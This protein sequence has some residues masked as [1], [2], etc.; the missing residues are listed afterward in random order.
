M[1]VPPPFYE[2]VRKKDLLTSFLDDIIFNLLSLYPQKR[3]DPLTLLTQEQLLHSIK[4]KKIELKLK[5]KIPAPHTFKTRWPDARS[6]NV[7]YCVSKLTQHPSGM[8][9][10][11]KA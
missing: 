10:N 4:T 2:Q 3:S 11:R 9:L 7:L 8:Y 1:L 5:D 6:A